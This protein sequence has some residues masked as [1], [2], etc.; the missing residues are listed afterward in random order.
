LN[1][2]RSELQKSVYVPTIYYLHIPPICLLYFYKNADMSYRPYIWRK[3]NPDKRREQKK[4]ERIRRKLRDRGI[5]PPIGS[6]MNEEQK[7]IDDQ[8]SNNDFSYWEENYKKGKEHSGGEQIKIPIKNKEYLIW[9]R[10]KENAKNKKLDFDIDVED[11]IVPQYCP[12]L[13]VE[14][15]YE[16]KYHRAD[17]YYTIDRIDSAKGYI[18]GNVQIL[19]YLA[20]IMKNK[21]TKEQL[22]TFSKNILELYKDDL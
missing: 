5:L 15:K 18:K 20:N 10:A 17:E 16:F 14:L 11:I 19:S 1:N 12:L 6:P 3:N 21:S 7:I 8:I 13:G 2:E 4:R 9:Y 22:I